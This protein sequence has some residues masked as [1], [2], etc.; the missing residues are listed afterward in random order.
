[1]SLQ[2]NL[3]L[4][5]LPLR[6]N[7]LF[8]Q[9]V[10]PLP[11]GRDKSISLIRE[12]AA[13][14]LRIVTLAQ[15]DHE[16]NEPNENDLYRIGTVSRILK[17]VKISSSS[18]SVILQGQE[19]V[20]LKKVTQNEPFLIGEFETITEI[21]SSDTETS[22]LFQNMKKAAKRMIQ[23]M[24]EMPR[25]V[26]K[27]LESPLEPG[28]LADFVTPIMKISTENKQKILGSL[29]IKER[30]KIVLTF[31]TNALEVEEVS[32]KISS[33]VKK[34]IDRNQKEFYLRQQVKA[35]RE[36]LGEY[37]DDNSEIKE[38]EAQI[39]KKKLTE[40]ARK[41]IKKQFS[42]LQQMQPSSSE[43]G[44]IRTYLDT[45]LEL[46]W[47]DSST[48]N[49]DIKHAKKIL[50]NEHYGLEKVKER[51]IEFLAVRK[52][53]KDMKGP[54]LCLVGP[55][56]VGKTSLGR[57][58]AH[59]LN[60]EFARISLGGVHDE[61]EIRG[62][63]R[64]YVGA[65]PG[66]IIQALRKVKTNNP[67][68]LLDEID[69]IGQDR[70]GDPQ[71]ALLEVLDSEQN[72]SFSDH[73]IEIPFDLSKI[74]FIANANQIDTISSP[75]RDRMEVIELPGYTAKE[76]LAIL[77]QFLVPKQLKEHG[78][79]EKLLS[80]TNNAL[81]KIIDNYTREAGVRAA[82]RKVA[83]ICRKAA[84]SIVS[85]EI[86]ETLIVDIGDIENYLGPER[87]EREM[88]S[89]VNNPGI[90]TGLAWTPVG[91]DILF[92]EAVKM[93]GKGDLKL[94]GKLGD[95]MKE[96]ALAALSYLRMRAAL[97]GL[98][99]DFM[100]SFDL[101]IHFPAG[102][103]PK[104]GPSAGITIFTTLLSLFTG[105]KVREDVAMTG[106][107]TLRGNILP[108]GGIKEKTLAAHRA[109]VKRIIMPLRNKKDLIDVADEVKA[110]IKFIFVSHVDEIPPFALSEKI[111]PLKIEL[112]VES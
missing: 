90:A 36:E 86:K 85:E 52:L 29:H 58:I 101:H 25:E 31:L 14:E 26:S 33:Q 67:V 40:E 106:E 43:Y 94:T 61:A 49:L 19:R 65:L 32:K 50:D 63:R 44:V 21:T 2:K 83:A 100:N 109:G 59:A 82:E 111:E 80:I 92:I 112:L 24:P 23:H 110:N 107:I 103:I 91:G 54:I 35:I 41:T 105:I 68:M 47:L 69:K 18:Y 9:I 64:T 55:P 71:S 53:R 11:V 48:D 84:V 4:P 104:D 22:A 89:R 98:P 102:A 60:R 81:S 42:R 3:F 16:V 37:D 34:E 39:E 8:P 20:R 12:A 38:F 46:P 27:I 13:K 88:I 87:Y 62:H 73:Y 45:L 79:D 97:F 99:N 56:G 7:V 78:I 51:L 76:K 95:V 10:I 17:V 96:S 74:L 15:K 93:P 77:K 75:L 57:S 28:Q 1:M 108:V 5:I 70:R 6:N 72:D 30:L 66:R